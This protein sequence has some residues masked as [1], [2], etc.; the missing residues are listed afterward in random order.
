MTHAQLIAI[1][2]AEPDPDR[3]VIKLAQ[4]AKELGYV[5]YTVAAGT[6]VKLTVFPE[7]FA[8][9]NALKAIVFDQP[10]IDAY[11]QTFGHTPAQHYALVATNIAL[12]EWWGP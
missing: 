6:A 2:Q 8:F 3:R 12:K 7:T 11:T 4:I 5:Q 1:A 9:V 10:F